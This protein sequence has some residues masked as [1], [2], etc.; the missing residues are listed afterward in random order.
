[1]EGRTF[2]KLFVLDVLWL[3][4]EGVSVPIT[5][6][7]RYNPAAVSW[8]IIKLSENLRA[9]GMMSSV[10]DHSCLSTGRGTRSPVNEETR[11][12]NN[13]LDK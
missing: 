4:G 12:G 2:V 6:Q 3:P 5:S 7:E 11:G 10:L 13:R 9:C 8:R 1:M